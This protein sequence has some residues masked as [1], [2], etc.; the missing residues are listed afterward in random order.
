MINV[1]DRWRE[2]N[3]WYPGRSA[4]Y[5]LTDL[6]KS[7]KPILDVLWNWGEEYKASLK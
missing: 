7:L 2:R 4:R 6:G 5:S 3:V 1:A